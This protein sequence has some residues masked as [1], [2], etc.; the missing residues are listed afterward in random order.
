ME[1]CW[2]E[3]QSVRTFNEHLKSKKHISNERNKPVKPEP[4]KVELTT[5][6]DLTVCL[7]CNAKSDSFA[8]LTH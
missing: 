1:Y 2:K 6:E 3:F 8:R 7:F 5:K 4:V